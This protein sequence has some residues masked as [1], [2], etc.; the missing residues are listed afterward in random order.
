MSYVIIDWGEWVTSSGSVN[1]T[2]TSASYTLGIKHFVLD[3]K[4]VIT[5]A[6]GLQPVVEITCETE[7]MA[8]NICRALVDGGEWFK[9]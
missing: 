1:P 7:D 3:R 6:R 5:N 8:R 2:L 4:Y 9:K